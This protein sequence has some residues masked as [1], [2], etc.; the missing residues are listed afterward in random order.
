MIRAL[1]AALLT[2]AIAGQA[3]ARPRKPPERAC[4]YAAFWD[5]ADRDGE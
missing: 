3:D 4:T 2:L 1:L 5:C